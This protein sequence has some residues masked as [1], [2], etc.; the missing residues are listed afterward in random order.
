[1]LVLRRKK[2]ERVVIDGDIILTVVGVSANAVRLGIQAPPAVNVVRG[3]L[4]LDQDVLEPTA[5]RRG[6]RPGRD[7]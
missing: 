4:L 1:M 7:D 5:T 3:E 2:R 6:G